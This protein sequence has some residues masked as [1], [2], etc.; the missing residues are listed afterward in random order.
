MIRTLVLGYSQRGHLA[1]VLA[2]T[3]RFDVVLPLSGALGP[4]YQ[5]PPPTGGMTIRALQ[6]E[7]DRTIPATAGEAAFRAFTA[8]VDKGD[9][10]RVWAGHV[11]ATL[12]KHITQLLTATPSPQPAPARPRRAGRGQ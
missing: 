12:G 3:G 7:E 10:S 11:L 4:G 2:A 9:C 8:A 5:S 1:C 6:G